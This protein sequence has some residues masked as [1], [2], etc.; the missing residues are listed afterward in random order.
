MNTTT[1]PTTGRLS[2]VL[3][4]A[5][6][7]AGA[8]TACTPGGSVAPGDHTD[9][10]A[11]DLRE[12]AVAEGA[13]LREKGFEVS[14]DDLAAGRIAVPDGADAEAFSAASVECAQAVGG[15]GAGAAQ[16]PATPLSFGP[17]IASCVRDAGF[18]DF[19]DDPDAQADYQPRDEHGYGAAVARCA[20]EHGGGGAV[21]RQHG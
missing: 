9:P 13:C 14:D 3:A 7:A 5:L 6:L 2:T 10:S 15:R 8:L 17:E 4:T 1:K 20:A 21:E 16:G 18:P 19:P 11:G 12:R